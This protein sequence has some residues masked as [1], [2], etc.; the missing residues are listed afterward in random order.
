MLAVRL[1]SLVIG[2]SAAAWPAI[3]RPL[4]TDL[5]RT[6]DQAL[7]EDF[8]PAHSSLDIIEAPPY[9]THTS[10]V[11]SGLLRNWQ[12]RVFK[13]LNK[14]T[15]PRSASSSQAVLPINVF[16]QEERLRL[17][18]AADL[19]FDAT[20]AT[21]KEE[22]PRSL[23]TLFSPEQQVPQASTHG[24]NRLSP[25]PREPAKYTPSSPYRI[26]NNT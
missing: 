20:F 22:R 2:L 16:R 7:E 1:V 11:I 15:S 21:R 3:A 26:T 9:H 25:L 6:S 5:S 18:P 4:L 14:I 19:I 13:Q 24:R 12:G 23:Q 8:T 10:S 17:D